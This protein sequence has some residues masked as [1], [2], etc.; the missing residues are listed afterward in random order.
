MAPINSPSPEASTRGL[1]RAIPRGGLRIS[2]WRG[3]AG[4]L[5]W[6]A[7]SAS[8]GVAVE[9]PR[10]GGSTALL[11]GVAVRYT[12]R[13]MPRPASFRSRRPRDESGCRK[14]GHRCGLG[15][16]AWG[17]SMLCL[18]VAVLKSR[19]SRKP[20]RDADQTASTVPS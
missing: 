14:A 6:A 5:W 16:A 12:P 1:H 4:A 17:D 7:E 2:A 9:G 10:R 11:E 13:K 3:R 18:W 15:A 19:A 20:A 8:T